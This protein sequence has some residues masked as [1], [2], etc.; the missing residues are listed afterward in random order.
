MAREIAAS[1]PNALFLDLEREADR[2]RLA[3]A[4]L[5]F[6]RHRD[7][8]VI[9]DEVQAVPDLFARLRPEIDAD[10]RAGRFLLLGSA[11]GSLLRQSAESLAGRIAY[12]ELT[13]FLL[14]ELV[15]AP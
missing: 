7:Q 10:R 8:L 2:A 3:R 11:S 6:S 5:F 12:L 1:S 15:A 14:D 13:P 4:D 9:L